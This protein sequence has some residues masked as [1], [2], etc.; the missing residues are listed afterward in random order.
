M[1]ARA[2]ADRATE[3]D[4]RSG[5]AGGVIVVIG[6]PA[7][8]QTGTDVSGAG[9]PVTIAAA[10]AAEARPVQL[11]GRV[12][13][14]PTADAVVLDLARRGIGHVALLR[15]AAHA[16]PMASVPLLVDDPASDEASDEAPDPVGLPL[17]AEDVDLGLRYLTG[18]DVLVLAAASESPMVRVVADAAGWAGARL[19]VVVPAGARPSTDLPGTAMV[20]EA[21]PADPDGAFGRLVGRLAASLDG[22]T[23]P[24]AALRGALVPD[25]WATATPD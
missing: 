5:Y 21:P 10:A 19:V 7:G 23:E 3:P 17:D 16:T 11:I 24:E 8:A 1:V 9:L 18:F 2:A 13:D 20:L 6:S 14:D 25:G 4:P 22:G 15:D 12:G